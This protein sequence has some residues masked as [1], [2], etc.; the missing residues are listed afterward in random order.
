MIPWQV[1]ASAEDA[2]V[3]REM[4]ETV[5]RMADADRRHPVD[6]WLASVQAR[7]EVARDTAREVIGLCAAT[8]RRADALLAAS[9]ER[10]VVGPRV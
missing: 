1:D 3:R 10:L 8:R 7:A 9:P 4:A 6:P 2:A 5:R